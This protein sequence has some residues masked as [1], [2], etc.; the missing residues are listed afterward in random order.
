MHM[1]PLFLDIKIRVITPQIKK[2]PL[3]LAAPLK[4]IHTKSVGRQ[5]VLSHEEESLLCERIITLADWGFPLDI[6]DLRM[7][8]KGYLE[9]RGI[10]VSRF[11]DNTPG[12]EWGL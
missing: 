12:H 8:V 5:T 3:K 2:Y 7:L 11:K 9:K 1:G 6:L 10:T 4:G